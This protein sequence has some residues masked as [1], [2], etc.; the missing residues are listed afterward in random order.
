M[1]MMRTRSERRAPPDVSRHRRRRWRRPPPPRPEM[2]ERRLHLDAISGWEAAVV[3]SIAG[4]HGTL[5]ERDAQI[6]RSGFYREYPAVLRAYHALFDDPASRLE[7]LKRALFIV[8]YGGV[9][10]PCHSAIRE[11]P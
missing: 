1:D 7:A 8:W 9:E 10:P 2:A 5:D 4:A 6:E 3:A 11:L